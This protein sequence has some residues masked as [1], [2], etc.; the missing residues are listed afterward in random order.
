MT[1]FKNN[2][3]ATPTK[4]ALNPYNPLSISDLSYLRTNAVAVPQTVAKSAA[5][6][7]YE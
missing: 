5:A 6:P 4:G 3:K 7:H 2:I 1:G